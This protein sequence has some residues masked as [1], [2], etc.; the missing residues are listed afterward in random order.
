LLLERLSNAF[1]PAGNEDEVRR[2]LARA[3][4]DKVDELSTDALGNLIA[5]KRGRGAKP[6]MKVMVDAHTDEVGL[7]I[8]RI[9]KKGLLGFQA[10]GGIND[11]LLLA[12][13]VVVGEKRLP[14]VITAPPIHLTKLS[15]RSQVIAIDQLAIDIGASS[16]DEARKLVKLGDYVAFDTRFQVLA[17]DGLRAA[18]GK[19]FD[20]RVGCAVAAALADE[21]YDVDL[22][23]SFSAQEEV[24]LRGARV[25]AF[26]IE[27]DVAFALEGTVCDDTPKKEDLSPTT[28]LGKGPAITMM[29]RSFFADKRLVQLL[30]GT[31]EAKGIAYQFK[32]PGVGATDAGPIHLTKS[33]VP[34]VTVAVPCR[35]IHTPV[36]MLSLNDYDNLVIL[37][38]AALHALPASWELASVS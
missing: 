13:G 16:E 8:T 26:R 37:M 19:A 29:D 10:V 18:K 27:P 31:A 28:E 34:A 6:R 7:M 9:E 22:Y 33:G 14:G 38:K 23:L 36:S 20:D 30:V 35:Y 1:G 25:A 11:R 24:G 3:L 12:K 15:Q 17:K 5:F 21:T 2:I 4:K 32:Q